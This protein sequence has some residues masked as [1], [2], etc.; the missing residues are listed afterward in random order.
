[1]WSMRKQQLIWFYHLIWWFSCVGSSPTWQD[2]KSIL[3]SCL[4]HLGISN[5]FWS[6][7]NLVVLTRRV[8]AKPK[9]KNWSHDFQVQNHH[10][11]GLH[12]LIRSC[13]QGRRHRAGGGRGRASFCG[14]EV[15]QLK[16]ESCEIFKDRSYSLINFGILEITSTKNNLLIVDLC[17]F[18]P[19][20]FFGTQVIEGESTCWFVLGILKG[21]NATG[22]VLVFF[23]WR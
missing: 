1:M 18:L 6:S 17:W 2:F 21:V 4:Y 15:Q 8:Y 5:R 22:I 3:F 12:L 19:Y 16:F 20:R 14:E 23:W 13:F 9:V 7:V 10:L 11:L